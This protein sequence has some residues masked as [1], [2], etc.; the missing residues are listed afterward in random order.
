MDEHK[1]VLANGLS[2][3]CP[4]H[5]NPCSY[6]R[7]CKMN[8]DDVGYWDSEEWKDDPQGVMGAILGACA[9]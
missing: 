6:V 2:I 7:V 1:L 8:G 9:V 5:P 3:V 4:A